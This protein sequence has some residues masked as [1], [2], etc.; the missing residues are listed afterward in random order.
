[1]GRISHPRNQQRRGLWM[2]GEP[3]QRSDRRVPGPASAARTAPHRLQPGP[4]PA[5]CGFFRFRTA[6]RLT[7]RRFLPFRVPGGSV[8]T[9]Q[10]KRRFRAAPLVKGGLGFF[11]MTIWYY[12]RHAPG[13]L[14]SLSEDDVEAFMYGR[15]PLPPD[16]DHRSFTSDSKFMR[17]VASFSIS[18]ESGS[19]VVP[20]EQGRLDSASLLGPGGRTGG[21]L[22]SP[23]F[24]RDWTTTY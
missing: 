9:S 21:R 10:R 24:A 4:S 3:H 22:R 19:R 2:P 14:S 1:L 12:L 11:L 18:A 23:R 13:D 20:R 6:Q 16:E 7:G 5:R 8:P 17:S 15:A